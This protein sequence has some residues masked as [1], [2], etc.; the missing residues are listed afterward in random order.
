LRLFSFFAYICLILLTSVFSFADVKLPSSTD[1]GRI[2]KQLQPAP[3]PKSEPRLSVPVPAKQIPPEKADEIQFELSGIT[4]QGNTVYSAAELL[5]YWQDLLGKKVT[6]TQVYAVA[7]AITAHYRNAGY[8]LTQ[9]IIPPQ[10]INNGMVLI[11]VIE[12]HAQDVLI[13]G[14]VKGRQGLFNAWVKKIKASKPLNNAVLERYTLIADDVNGL[15]VKSIIRP[16]KTTSGASDVV[17]VIEHKPL[18]ADITYDNR[19]TRAMGPRQVMA[20]L[21]ANSLFDLLERTDLTVLMTDDFEELRYYA[22]QHSQLLNSEGLTLNLSGNI[23]YSDLGDYLDD[24]DVEG[25]NKSFNVEL[26]YPLIRSRNKNLSCKTSLTVR[27]S[28]TDTMDELQSE[29]RLSIVKVGIDYD[30]T[31]RWQGVNMVNLMYYGGLDMFGSR[32]TGSDHL[33]RADGH[34]QFAKVTLDLYRR[35]I[36]PANF[37][38][39]IAGTAQWADVSLLSSEEFGYGGAQYGRAYD[40]SSITGDRGLAGKLELQYSRGFGTDPWNY[41]QLYAFYDAGRTFS[42]SPLKDENTT[43]QSVGGGVR[44]AWSQYLSGSVE[45]AQPLTAHISELNRRDD[46]PRVFFNVTAKY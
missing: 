16:S 9:A 7:D 29:D 15:T 13:E 23:S 45:V 34:S 46:S 42:N 40:S 4:L 26:A 41:Y 39:L 44:F 37:S 3:E 38:L 24:Y 10:Q 14:D 1:P 21:G 32:E 35:Q 36:L 20:N 17:L 27:H 43:G 12:G 31:D 25:R 30:Y 19:G 6:L 11:K 5:G 18:D 28:R 22:L 2:E 33:T 8:I